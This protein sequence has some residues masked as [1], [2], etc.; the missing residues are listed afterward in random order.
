V[1]GRLRIFVSV[2]LD[3]ETER[4]V[5]GQA[6]ASLPVSLGWE[7][8]Y[9]P[10][11]GERSDPTTAAVTNCDFYALLLGT[12]ISAPIGSELHA[13]LTTG[14]RIVAL[15]KEGPRTAA[16]RF[17]ARQSRLAWRRFDDEE[18]LRHLLQK[19]IVEQIL[20][21]PE[22]YRITVADWEALSALSAE[23]EEQTSKGM[24][25]PTPW[26]G[27][28]GRDAVIVSPERDLPSEGVAIGGGHDSS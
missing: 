27:G 9:T 24:E 17:F 19:S 6:I 13:A 12:D 11:R 5:V 2:G 18:S 21:S 8:K 28:A 3:L 7:I 14:K 15:L 4:E 1:A 23:L 26:R 22:K 10:S 25:E 20:D 16:A